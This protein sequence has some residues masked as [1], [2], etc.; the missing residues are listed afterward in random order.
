MPTPHF[1]S[2]GGAVGALLREHP[3]A[4]SP[5]GPPQHWPSA[6]QGLVQIMLA[7]NQPMFIVW[8]PQRVYLY[9]DVYTQILGAKHPGALGREFLGVWAEIRDEIE[10]L[11][12]RAYGGEPVQMED[13]QLV[14][15]RN[16]YPEETHFSFFYSPIRGDDA[17]V[18]GFF[19]AVN[20]RTR[21]IL[22]QRELRHS[23]AR[24][25]RVLANM[26]EGFLLLDADFRIADVNDY[27]LR[28]NGMARE[29]M[30]GRLHWDVFP[31]SDRLEVGR[32]YMH[33]MADGQAFTFEHRYEWPDG[34][35]AWIELRGYPTPDGL[36]IFFRDVSD[37]REMERR[38]AESAERVQ[39]ALDAGAI[40]GTWVWDVAGDRIVADER[41]ARTFGLDVAACHAGM[42]L[43][44]AFASI[45]PDDRQRVQQAI[46]DALVRGGPYRCE[47]R[48]LQQDGLYHLIEAN[49]RCERDAAGRPVRFPGVLLDVEDRRR[50]EAERDQANTM[51]RT[52]IEAVPGVVYAKDREGR[53]QLANRGTAELIGKPPAQF[54]GRTDVEVLEDKVH[55]A[56]VMANDRRIMDSGRAEQVE[57]VVPT[58]DGATVYWLSHKAPLFDAQGRV[59]GLIGASVDITER[60]REQER[61]RTEAEMLDLLNQTAAL[62]A[63]ELDL[64]PLL[65]S[66]TDAATKLTG[67]QFGAF[68]Y[69]GVDAQGETYMLFA[70]SGAPRSAFERFGQPRPTP[71]F[72]PTF[73]GGPPIRIDDVRKDPRYGGW[74]PH[75]GMPAGHL[76]VR[77]YLA[78][79]VV[80]RRGD[81]I[82]GLFF[83]HPQPGVFT[84]RSERLAAGIASQAAV[85]IDNARLYAEAQRAAEERT[86]L[87]ESERA[88]RADA[89]R[90]S[91]LKDEFLATL[92]HELRT[93]LSAILGWAHILRR[94]VG[95]DP[96][97]AKGI[98]VIERSTRV[99]TQLIEDLLDMSRITSGKLR[100][101]LQP[102][103]PL[104]FVQAAIDSVKPAA[105]A[106][107]VRVTLLV[108]DAVA[109]VMGD[110]ARLQQV[111]WNLLSNAIKFSPAG[112]EVLVRVAGDDEQVR[113]T[114]EDAGVGIPPAFLPYVFDRFRQA[115]G[116]T[117][118]RFGGLGLGL[119]IVRH[120]ADLHGGDVVATS[121]GEG[122]GATFVVT[123]PA[124]GAAMLRVREGQPEPLHGETDLRG[125]SVLVVDDE[126]DVLDLL[127]RV[128]GEARADVTAVGNAQEALLAYAKLQP[129]LLISDIGMPGMD[130]YELMRRVRRAPSSGGTRVQAIAL[131]A[132]ARPEDRKRAL[133]SGF[134]VYLS[135]PIEPHELVAQV[136]LLA[137]RPAGPP[138]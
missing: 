107:R 133:D 125:L 24:H 51:L 2:G 117:T 64:E 6:L 30:V 7:S 127:S 108:E 82:G 18:A 45:H 70:L 67:A 72:E 93:P 42:A 132:F 120:L 86:L 62:L 84:E 112:G 5:L 69:N 96:S 17:Q 21:E 135:K 100:L 26:D 92:S 59:T 81:V 50:A 76:P 12:R 134:D 33:A 3:W 101:D 34:R 57:E 75:H 44:G 41:F 85:A 79:S 94:K 11:V 114:V 129:R 77:S 13:M 121:G 123:L 137:E 10:P 88:A 1:L 99:Q 110:A 78:V 98:D 61:A 47:Y 102:V 40:V 113:I 39:L 90:A 71:I 35:K 130:G 97:M 111:V 22:A 128:L 55:A 65:Q 20:E 19:C 37:R 27:A 138:H 38:A 131:T 124:H 66:V 9:N 87:L 32:R 95:E 58:P 49:G 60:K 43:E 48:V 105:D 52:F 68:F 54:I 63:G 31:G 15:H 91:T 4:D 83:G 53:L 118:R 109:S 46:A 23:E 16:G 89:E 8:G 74:G 80:S 104:A 56:L 106:A 126:P 36:A 136:R 119:S 116:S 14:L 115:D 122:R 103:M 28:L 29:Q 25:R 73:R